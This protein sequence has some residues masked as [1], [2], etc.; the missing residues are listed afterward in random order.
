MRL[1]MGSLRWKRRRTG[2]RQ[3]DTQ[4][5]ATLNPTEYRA[6]R[7]QCAGD[8]K[9][10]AI[11]GKT[12]SVAS[13]DKAGTGIA[14]EPTDPS[15]GLNFGTAPCPLGPVFRNGQSRLA[16]LQGTHRVA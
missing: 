2:V 5:R 9:R 11:S 3:A 12:A 13:S 16:S 10:L 15:R 7:P 6:R 14:P 4:T 1:P 8:G